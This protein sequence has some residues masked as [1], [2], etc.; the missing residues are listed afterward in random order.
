MRPPKIATSAVTAESAVTVPS[1]ATERVLIQGLSL[2][3]Y[4]I[5]VIARD[6]FGA[7]SV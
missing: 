6:Q 1:G 2:G 7:V 5:Q 3:A 4:K